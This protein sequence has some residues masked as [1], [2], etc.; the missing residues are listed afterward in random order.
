MH[1]NGYRL[2]PGQVAHPT[3]YLLEGAVPSLHLSRTHLQYVKDPE[4]CVA[5]CFTHVCDN[6]S[7]LFI[8]GSGLTYLLSGKSWTVMQC[9]ATGAGIPDEASHQRP[10][11]GLPKPMICHGLYSQVPLVRVCRQGG[12]FHLA[13]FPFPSYFPLL[14]EPRLHEVEDDEQ[15]LVGL[16]HSKR[17]S[18]AGAGH[19]YKESHI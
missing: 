15:S 16:S 4:T 13:D 7:I 11:L 3:L 10:L 9:I 5:L 8:R 19:L 12:S 17:L 2:V 1:A 18:T 14:A 6:S